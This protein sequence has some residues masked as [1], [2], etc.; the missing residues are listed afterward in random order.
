MRRPTRGRSGQR[1]TDSG[2]MAVELV[3]LAPVLLAFLLVV[4]A[5]GRYVWV[6]GDIE[7]A[8]RDAARAASLERSQGAG[9]IA[10]IQTAKAS[11][12]DKWDCTAE[13]VSP[14]FDSGGVATIRLTCQVSWSGLGLIGLKGSKEVE[15]T[16]SAPI[17]LYRRTG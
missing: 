9:R 14:N 16:S 10:A 5:M 1:T 4:V 17:D 15:A 13:D 11:L 3:M 8:S 6:R 2:S 7:A 12:N